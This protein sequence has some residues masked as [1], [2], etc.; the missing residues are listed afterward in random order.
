M[1]TPQNPLTAQ[2][3]GSGLFGNAPIERL[4]IDYYLNLLTSEYQPPS[5]PKLNAF[6]QVLLQKFD[7]I[8]L[9]AVSMDTAFD[10]DLAVG[11]QL[12][13]IGAIV[14]AN[15]TVPFQPTGSISPVL[16][17]NTYRIYIKAVA[18]ANQWDGTIDS[19]QGIWE[20]LFPG[21]TITIGDNQNMTVTI[22]LTGTY[23]SIV[24]QLITNGLIVPRPEG[25]LYNYV[26]GE[27][28]AF[29]LDL[30]NTLIAGLDTGYFT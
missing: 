26:F 6:L 2:G 25:V 1:S 14:G 11:V 22:F 7:D 29:G 27:L 19:L 23:T 15:R 30:D 13:M 5:S 28:P 18:A 3:Y 8:S 4:G 16:D 10:V 12:D 21:L 24:Q 20:I 9:C 17:D